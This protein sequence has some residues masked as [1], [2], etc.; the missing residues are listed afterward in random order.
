MSLKTILIQKEAGHGLS[1]L[2][3]R[4]S[5]H[6]IFICTISCNTY[7]FPRTVIFGRGRDVFFNQFLNNLSGI[8]KLVQIVL[9]HCFFS[10]LFQESFSFSKLIVLLQSTLK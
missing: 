4:K 6:M 3:L 5:E 1:L 8:V 2:Q 7:E 9:E 10:K